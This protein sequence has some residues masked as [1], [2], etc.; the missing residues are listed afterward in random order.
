MMPTMM[1]GFD[2]TYSAPKSA[3][4]AADSALTS[5]GGRD[6]LARRIALGLTTAWDLFEVMRR[7]DLGCAEWADKTIDQILASATRD[8]FCP[9][10]EDTGFYALEHPEDPAM[11]TTLLRQSDQDHYE[12]LSAS[13]LW[14]PWSDQNTPA[15]V[16]GR[17]VADDLA[18]VI[19]A[20]GAGLM[21]RYLQPVAWLNP[22]FPI[23]AANDAPVGAPTNDDAAAWVNYALVDNL[24]PGA[25]LQLIRLAPGPNL[26]RYDGATKAWTADAD[27]L[28]KLQ[29]VSPPPLVELDAPTYQDVINQIDTNATGHGKDQE[30]AKAKTAAVSPDPRAEKLRQYWS[31]GKG[32]AKIRWGTHGDWTRCYRYLSKYM[33]PRA[34]GYCQNLHKRNTGVYTG[35]RLNA[36]AG[37]AVSTEAALMASLTSGQWAGEGHGKVIDMPNMVGIRDGVY[38]EALD[39]VVLLRAMTAGAFPVKPPDGWFADPK[40]EGPTPLTVEDDGQ[41]RGHIATFDVAHIGLPGRVH[42]P[43]S[44][45]NYAYFKTGVLRTA[46]G[47][48]IP[49]GQLTLAG[50]HAPLAADAGTAVAHY[51][52]TASAVADVNIGEDRYGIWVA[53]ALRPEIK[54]D[55]VRTLRASAPSGDWRPINGHLELVAICQVNVPGFPVA[56]ARVA[57]GAITALV[58]AGARPLAARRA[59]LMADAAMAERVEALENAVFATGSDAP[60]LVDTD[61]LAGGEDGEDEEVDLIDTE[62]AELNE[63]AE[64]I[65]EDE[66][67]ES[68]DEDEETHEP[69]AIDRARQ[70]VASRRR[71]E[72]RA[73]VHGTK[74]EDEMEIDSMLAAGKKASNTMPD[75][76]FPIPDVNHL[77][78]AIKAHGRAKNKAAVKRHIKSRAKALGRSDLVP[79]DWSGTSVAAAAGVAV[80]EGKASGR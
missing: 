49:V 23:T 48:D 65:E 61:G 2:R 28:S 54:P 35:S 74:V 63:A 38:A 18:E 47:K 14:E 16:I 41:V 56:R 52:E 78:K 29:G 7:D 57:S 62:L 40:M 17:D 6:Q 13:G 39:N 45:S 67:E 31:T 44:R 11:L 79:N 34:K 19:L 64:R 60:D 51:D 70:A 32:A 68:T 8:P 46:G 30:N 33:G 59:S 75:G 73:R 76:S 69:T 21:R 22:T 58:A 24:D 43:R 15:V 36:S 80:G 1:S 42:A 5:S 10:C 50:G 20:G 55:Q 66:D 72:M 12:K 4:L 71:A 25:V 77:K 27:I 9:E 3:R 53:G 37:R 26:E